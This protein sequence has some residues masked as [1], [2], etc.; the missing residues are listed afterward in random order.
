MKVSV[1]IP[2]YNKIRYLSGLL[3][4]VRGQTL[5]DF[6]C[7]LID[8][9]STDGSG[10]VCDE[11]AAR[12]SRFRVFHIPNGGVSHARNVGL[13]TAQGEYVTFID[14]DD[15]IHPDLLQRLSHCAESND[16][17]MVIGNLQKIWSDRDEVEPLVI[18]YEG[19]Y[20]IEALLPEFAEVQQRVGIYGFCV[21][22]LLKRDLIADTRFDCNI[23]LA[24][25]L[26]FYLD[27]YPRVDS[28]YFDR[29][30][31]YGYLQGAENSSML[32]ADDRIDYF[33]QL[34]IQQ[35]LLQFLTNK[36]VQDEKTKKIMSLRIY[37]YVFFSLFHCKLREYR[38]MGARI[39]ALELPAMQTCEKEP[40]IRRVLLHMHANGSVLPA[41]VFLAGYRLARGC[42]RWIRK[43]E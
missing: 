42:V 22:K 43:G 34:T 36:G 18:P 21:A 11:F 38:K 14:S 35:K 3:E 32:G 10:E 2:V 29:M 25:D 6:E 4:Q 40:M 39:G 24:E 37:D 5:R 8:D 33:T 31:C 1:I 30:P 16:V 19:K 28:L 26:A 41:V 17:P 9:G 13:D 7:L 27:I 20:S 12:D 15:S 23:R